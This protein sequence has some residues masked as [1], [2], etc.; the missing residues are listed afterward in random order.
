MG[1]HVGDRLREHIPGVYSV[2]LLTL[3]Q[4]IP[5]VSSSFSSVTTASRKY[6]GLLGVRHISKTAA[7][8]PSIR[9]VKGNTE[10]AESW[11]YK[12][13]VPTSC[14]SGSQALA[15]LH[16]LNV[17]WDTSL[18][19]YRLSSS[20]HDGQPSR[21]YNLTDSRTHS[22]KKFLNTVQRVKFLFVLKFTEDHIFPIISNF[23]CFCFTRLQLLRRT[24]T[25]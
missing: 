16:H 15:T 24:W 22:K 1:D 2:D 23:A 10:C 25:T 19:L 9:S 11:I 18:L 5:S 17:F 8:E 7:A 13:L 6:L 14:R 3:S 12:N 4:V 21:L 20:E